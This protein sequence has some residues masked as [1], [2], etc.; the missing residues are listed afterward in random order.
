M[1][2]PDPRIVKILR[3]FAKGTQEDKDR[4]MMATTVA[5]PI[6]L[7]L[8]VLGLNDAISW[9]TSQGMSG[10]PAL[11][12]ELYCLLIGLPFFMVPMIVVDVL[13]RRGKVNVPS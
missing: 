10:F 3:L 12:G 4:F 11:L 7:A 2:D 8:L 1:T 5:L 6:T 9:T 13:E